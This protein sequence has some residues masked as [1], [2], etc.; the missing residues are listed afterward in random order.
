MPSK[1]YWILLCS[2]PFSLLGGSFRLEEQTF[3]ALLAG[4]L[5]VSGLWMLYL[6]SQSSESKLESDALQKI[7]PPNT[8]LILLC[9]CIPISLLAGMV[10]IGGGIF[11]AP[12]LHFL[13]L[14]SPKQIATIC[15][16]YI[17]INSLSGLS[18]QVYKLY[19]IDIQII[20]ENFWYLLAVLPV[21]TAIGGQIGSYSGA[22]LMQHRWIKGVCGC[23][24]LVVA[25]RIGYQL[26]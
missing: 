24:I 22:F 7:I 9:V 11:L 14:A 25:A 15:A 19:S 23:L 10:G 4:T 1:T 20:D 5:F 21:T 8:S 12:L 16:V 13:H 3:F 6:T 17:L 2:A 18:G 26:Y